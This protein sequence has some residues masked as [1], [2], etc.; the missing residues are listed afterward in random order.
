MSDV[1]PAPE[2]RVR[3]R[4]FQPGQSGNP[5]GRMRGSQNK[6]TQMLAALLEAEAEEV[7]RAVVEKAKQGDLTAAKIVLDRLLPSRRDRPLQFELPSF[8]KPGDAVTASTAVLAAVASGDLTPSEGAEIA[9]LIEGHI[10]VL[11]VTDFEQR[12]RALEARGKS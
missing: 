10:R 9:K 5:Q 8:E 1:V 7:T 2:Q 11:E 6:T 3:G 4:P 12:L